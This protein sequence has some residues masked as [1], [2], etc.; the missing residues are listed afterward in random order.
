MKML[1]ALFAAS[2]LLAPLPAQAQALSDPVV[3]APNPEALFTSRDP[4]LHRNKQ[5]ALKIVK[6]LLEAGQWSRA[7]QYLTK[8]YIQHNPVAASGV[9]AVMHYFVDIAKVQPKPVPERMQTKVVAVQA[10][11]DYVTVSYVR[12][13]PDPK[14]PGKTYTTTWFDMW[15]FVDGKADEHWDPMVLPPAPPPSPETALREA[16]DRAAIAQLEWDY[17]RAVDTLN[18]VAYASVFTPDGAFNNTKGSA[19]LSKMIVDMRASQ[20]ERRAK[21]VSIPPMYHFMANQS[22]EFTDADHARVR[23]YWQTVFAG[24]TLDPA[25]RLAAAG[26]GV[27]DVVRTG[28]RWLISS[29]NVAPTN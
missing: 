21:G 23:Y 22:I 20:D 19:A 3:A 11:G 24:P 5:T 14:N 10:E 28:G 16:Q 2:M 13:M 25:P 7:P 27:D 8:R 6:E 12:E 9:D 4:I 26:R 17:S 1:P 29:R 15:R 18:P